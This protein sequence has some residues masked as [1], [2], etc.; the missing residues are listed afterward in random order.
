MK[1]DVGA[2]SAPGWAMG[3]GADAAAAGNR[4]SAVS[5][6]PTAN[7]TTQRDDGCFFIDAVWMRIRMGTAGTEAGRVAGSGSCTANP[8]GRP[9]RGACVVPVPGVSG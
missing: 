3:C 8:D 4:P 9:N 5:S 1:T 2:A 7:E 6:A